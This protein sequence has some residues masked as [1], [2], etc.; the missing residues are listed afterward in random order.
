[1]ME[2]IIMTDFDVHEL[3]ME[4]YYSEYSATLTE[5]PEINNSYYMYD[6]TKRFFDI[7]C[8]LIGIVIGL[9]IMIIFSVLISLETPGSPI[10]KQERVGLNGRLFTL[11]KLRSMHND[12]EKNGAQWADKDDCRVTKIGNFIRDR[13]S[14]V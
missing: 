3:N 12:A 11:Y 10:Y 4:D 14:V 6:Y 7:V 8:S 9:T 1:M 2:G 13:K 5:V